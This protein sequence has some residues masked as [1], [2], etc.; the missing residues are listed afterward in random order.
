MTPHL[1]ATRNT[2]GQLALPQLPISTCNY[3][4]TTY[5]VHCALIDFAKIPVCENQ[6]RRGFKSFSIYL[7]QDYNRPWVFDLKITVSQ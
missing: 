4:H 5:L 7:F 3:V 2:W 1:Q 6:G